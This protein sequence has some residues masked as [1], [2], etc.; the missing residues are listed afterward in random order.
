[1]SEIKVLKFLS[2]EDCACTIV[3]RN[4]DHLIVEDVITPV[5]IGQDQMGFAPWCTLMGKNKKPVTV[6]KTA[7][8]CEYEPDDQLI[9]Q[10]QEMFSKIITPNSKVKIV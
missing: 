8:V 7:I 2:G 6:Y 5:P 1:M 4:E 3:E 10:Y 9:N